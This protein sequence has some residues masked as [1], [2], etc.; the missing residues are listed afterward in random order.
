MSE[1][2]FRNPKF[3]IRDPKENRSLKPE[4]FRS[5]ARLDRI[6]SCPK[7]M[8]VSAIEIRIS[9]ELRE[10]GFRNPGSFLAQRER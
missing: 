8:L 2:S 1:F 5:A 4:K 6:V 9:F 7:A 3:E 10:F